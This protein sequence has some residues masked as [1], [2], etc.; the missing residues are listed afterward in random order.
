MLPIDYYTVGN[1][2]IIKDFTVIDKKKNIGRIQLIEALTQWDI[3]GKEKII[4]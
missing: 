3:S 4:S 2:F 1:I